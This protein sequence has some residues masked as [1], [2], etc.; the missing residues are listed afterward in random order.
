MCK[1]WVKTAHKARISPRLSRTLSPHKSAA[2]TTLRI[3]LGNFAH[4]YYS[5]FPHLCTRFLSKLTDTNHNFYTIST[6]LIISKNK[7]TPIS[8]Y[9]L[10][11][12]KVLTCK[13]I[14]L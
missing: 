14:V 1:T 9:L 13:G 3:N 2:S 4:K 5:F 11:D 12:G 7:A 6:G 10:R 8:F